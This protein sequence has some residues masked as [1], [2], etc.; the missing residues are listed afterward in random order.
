MRTDIRIEDYSYSLPEERIAK[1]PLERRDDSRLLVY[2]ES[3]GRK[4]LSSNFRDIAQFLPSGSLMVFNETKVVPARLFFVRPTGALIEI[5]C[6]EPHS[7]SD[8]QLNFASQGCCRWKTIVGNLKK[9]KGET[10][11]LYNPSQDGSVALVNLT[12]DLVDEDEKLCV[13]EFRWSGNASF[14]KVLSICGRIPIP[15]YLKRDTQEIDL[16]RYQTCYAL[17]EGSVAAP[18]AG[19]HFTEREFS[20]I[21]RR[22]ILRD[23]LCLHVGAGT[24]MPVKSEYIAD[25]T[26]HSEPFEVS[27]DFLRRLR[28]AS[29]GDVI[30]VGTTSTRCLESL[31]YIGVHIIETGEPGEVEQWEPYRDEGYPYSLD[32]SLDAVIGYIASRGESRIVSRTR[33]IIIPG[34]RFR[35]IKYLVTNFHQPQ[36]TLLLLVAAL[37]GESWRDLYDFALKGGFR[38]LSYGDSSLLEKKD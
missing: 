12:A 22:G 1:F 32:E 5:F 37:I 23:K 3:T 25:H 31:Y 20:D 33:I 13:V 36:S 17:R 15:P 7:P 18:T 11:H 16:V 8:Y 28:S 9:W 2:T 34:F 27:L 26:M 35:V 30:A 29:R 14:S 21:D 4:P 10:L 38:F 6:L 19:L 24:F